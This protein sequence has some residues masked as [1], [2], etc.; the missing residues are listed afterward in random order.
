MIRLKFIFLLAT[1]FVVGIAKADLLT[2]AANAYDK[3]EY[4]RAS[5]LFESLAEKGNVKAQ[6][7]LGVMYRE[8]QGVQ[9]NSLQ[10]IKWFSLAA[11]QGFGQAQTELGVMF[12]SDD[13]FQN[14][15]KAKEL[16]L[17]AAGQAEAKAMFILGSLYASAWGVPFDPMRA[18]MWFNLFMLSSSVA[19]DYLLPKEAVDIAKNMRKEMAKAMSRDQINQAQELSVRCVENRFINC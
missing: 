1:V 19:D 10:A 8:G 18:Y 6:T 12:M 9:K 17:L 5:I 15:K 13:N 11:K 4:K 2:D 14:Y 7:V 3:G 16:F